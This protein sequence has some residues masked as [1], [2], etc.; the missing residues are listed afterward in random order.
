MVTLGTR[1]EEAGAGW[2]WG[3]G[4]QGE[5]GHPTGES[6]LDSRPEMM[7][8]WT[9]VVTMEML[10]SNGFE[11]GLGTKAKGMTEE[12][13]GFGVGGWAADGGLHRCRAGRGAFREGTRATVPSVLHQMLSR[14]RLELG[15]KDV[16]AK[17][18]AS[19]LC[20]PFASVSLSSSFS[21]PWF[22]PPLALVWVITVASQLSPHLCTTTPLVYSQHSS[23]RDPVR[24]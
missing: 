11:T 24:I 6:D 7:A 9:E 8:V 12:S 3:E 14:C 23:Q 13:L 18:A 22:Q 4:A 5:E 21:S 20:F 17:Q 10:R 19:A 15:T 1:G 2:E 16:A